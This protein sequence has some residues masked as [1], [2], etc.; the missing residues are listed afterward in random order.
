MSRRSLSLLSAVCACVVLGVVAGCESHNEI[1]KA[2]LTGRWS[3]AS[4]VS[5]D[6][7]GDY[8]LDL[9]Q[10]IDITSESVFYVY[11]GEGA[12][13]GMGT[14]TFEGNQATFDLQTGSMPND[15]GDPETVTFSINDADTQMTIE[16]PQQDG[17]DFNETLLRLQ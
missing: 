13:I 12:Q 3:I 2:G 5:G 11:D 8:P 14:V 7:S 16:H 10:V 1:A 9:Q 6:Y 15:W 17:H 4:Y